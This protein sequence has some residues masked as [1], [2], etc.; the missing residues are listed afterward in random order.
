[1]PEMWFK[2]RWPDGESETCYSPSLVVRDYLREGETYPL[3]DFLTRTREALLI[4][5]DRVKLKFGRPCRL[6]L[7]QLASIERS[8]ARFA[9]DSDAQVTCERF[10]AQ[11]RDEP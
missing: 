5:S 3:D 11:P 7:E 10:L 9:D 8:S 1:M 2:V 4:A 6:A